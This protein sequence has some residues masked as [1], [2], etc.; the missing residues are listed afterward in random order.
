MKRF[1][2]LLLMLSTFLSAFEFN[3]PT[4]KWTLS[5][6]NDGV[7]HVVYLP[8]DIKLDDLQSSL[9]DGQELIIYNLAAYSSWMN[10]FVDPR[11]IMAI[12]MT[13]N[14]IE[15]LVKVGNGN[16]KNYNSLNDLKDYLNNQ[17]FTEKNGFDLNDYFSYFTKLKAA[18]VYYIKSSKNDL[19]F[20][21]TFGSSNY[22]GS[23]S[24]SS[25]SSSSTGLEMPPSVPDLN[26]SE[27]SSSSSNT[28]LTPP[29]I[30]QL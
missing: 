6:P 1:F 30:P 20:D 17:G 10:E 29:S 4:N 21:I 15:Y 28:L 23:S 14:K 8:V 22:E 19:K 2:I 13:N 12:K 11:F 16:V 24:S 26:S 18:G 9:A 7:V 27:G 5:V 25:S 3:I